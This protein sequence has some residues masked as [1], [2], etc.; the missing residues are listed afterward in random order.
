M[1]AHVA[2]FM[3]VLMMNEIKITFSKFF[4]LARCIYK[5][6]S[7]KRAMQYVYLA[8]KKGSGSLFL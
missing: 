5:K 2:I 8:P 3:P 7:P 6:V 1:D 4:S